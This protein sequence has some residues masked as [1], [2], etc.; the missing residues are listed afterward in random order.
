MKETFAG[1]NI[2]EAKLDAIAEHLL[3]AANTLEEWERLLGELELLVSHRDNADSLPDTA[4]LR[5]CGL[6]DIERARIAT[7][8]E[9]Q[10][11]LTLS[12]GE[13]EFSP[14]FSYGTSKDKGGFIPFG[15]ASAGQQ[16]TALLTVLL[17]QEGAPLII[18][19]PEDD[20]DSKMT[21]EIVKQ[22]WASKTKR[23][24]IFASHNANFV[25][26]GDAELVVC[27]DYSRVGD[28]TGGQIKAVGAI[29]NAKIREEITSV[30]EGG[31]EAFKLRKEKYGF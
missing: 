3:A 20:V 26:N 18:D 29:D 4:I 9:A 19:Q 12:I 17:S 8:L 7:G 1:L 2:R 6:T 13:L 27:C 30:T 5:K 22:V 31:R 16:A 25:V 28:Q 23:Q 14:V 15:D 11:W 24:L 21:A 10:K